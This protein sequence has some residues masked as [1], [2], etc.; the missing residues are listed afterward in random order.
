MNTINNDTG[1]YNGALIAA[2]NAQDVP[3]TDANNVAP[4][5]HDIQQQANIQQQNNTDSKTGNTQLTERNVAVAAVPQETTIEEVRQKCLDQCKIFAES[6]TLAD[7]DYNIKEYM[8]LN[9]QSIL[10]GMIG[11]GH[12]TPE[13]NE[14]YNNLLNDKN[15][16]IKKFKEQFFDQSSF[17]SLDTQSDSIQNDL[18]ADKISHQNR[19]NTNFAQSEISRIKQANETND[20][21]QMLQVL[22]DQFYDSTFYDGLSDL[23]DMFKQFPHTQEK[24]IKE[25]TQKTKAFLEQSSDEIY[26]SHLNITEQLNF[27]L[28]KYECINKQP[29]DNKKFIDEAVQHINQGIDSPLVREHLVMALLAVKELINDEKSG[30]KGK[31][32]ITIK[33]NLSGSSFGGIEQDS[34]QLGFY[35]AYAGETTKCVNANSWLCTFLHELGHMIDYTFIET[36]RGTKIID[37][38]LVDFESENKEKFAKD[39]LMPFPNIEKTVN[40]LNFL[41]SIDEEKTSK[42]DQIESLYSDIVWDSDSETLQ[43][44]GVRMIGRELIFR[45]TNDFA[46][47]C[48]LKNNS[49]AYGESNEFKITMR[50][51][52][53][54]IPTY[55]NGFTDFLNKPACD[56]EKITALINTLLPHITN[57]L[58]KDNFYECQQAIKKYGT[59]TNCYYVS[60]NY[61]IKS[62]AIEFLTNI[63][64]AKFDYDNRGQVCPTE[65]VLEL[66]SKLSNID[67][68]TINS[69][70]D[71]YN[72]S[73]KLPKNIT[74]EDFL[75]GLV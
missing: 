21:S 22:C 51:E 10:K 8:D 73:M 66:Y 41:E 24:D 13:E 72:N 54:F 4:E 18:L 49:K 44:V 11:K 32:S 53:N 26:G 45:R 74:I 43:I 56:N 7:N 67:N 52:H 35:L 6:K 17:N 63:L 60:N 34:Q 27:W 19:N 57:G 61:Y 15:A 75:Y 69:A 3:G 40:S 29:L 42:R 12:I 23:R 25:H 48:D 14:F 58:S 38:C 46:L 62:V 64:R 1:A 16:L 31:T 59:D 70:I 65:K 71:N 5:M 37:D 33:K 2:Q 55:V 20:E 50:N 28:K 68:S 47:T 36:E 30:Y 9:V 39:F